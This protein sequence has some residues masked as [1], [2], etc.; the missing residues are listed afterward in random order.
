MSIAVGIDENGLGP[1][2]GPLVVTAVT[3]KVTAQ[4]EQRMTHDPTVF[5]HDRL[6]D[7]KK[8]VSHQKVQLAEAW[9]RA[10]AGPAACPDALLQHL[11]LDSQA[12]R[13][14]LCPDSALPQCWSPHDEAFQASENQVCLARNDLKDLRSLG[15]DVLDAR[16]VI[17]CVRRLN[18][19][20]HRGVSRLDF[21]LQAMESLILAIV[22]H[23]QQPIDARCGKVGGMMRYPSKFTHLSGF[24]YG[25]LHEQRSESAYRLAGIGTIRFL[26]DAEEKDPLVSI[27]SLVGKWVREMLMNRI[28]R[29]YRQHDDTLPDASGYHDPVT[30]AFVRNSQALRQRLGI[31]QDC[32]LRQGKKDVC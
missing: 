3:A 9:A 1:Q 6:A 31:P 18:D 23:T 28:V 10:I 4:A 5:F 11:C 16:C 25:V 22:Q 26:Q 30:N 15:V 27:A 12:V 32:F 13:H 2:L 24:P 14:S 29:F 7:S 21:D 8:L 20:R 19:G 17:L